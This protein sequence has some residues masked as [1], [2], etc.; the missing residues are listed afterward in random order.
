[1]DHAHD[2][3]AT[4]ENSARVMRQACNCTL[5]KADVLADRSHVSEDREEL[6]Y[7]FILQLYIE[8]FIYILC[9]LHDSS[10]S[11]AV[12]LTASVTLTAVRCERV[13]AYAWGTP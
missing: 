9:S 10:V 8:T 3:T 2:N 12:T 1:M 11:T 5:R 6:K 13:P 7:Q 4:L